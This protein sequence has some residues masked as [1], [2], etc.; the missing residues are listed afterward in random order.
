[1][2]WHVTCGFAQGALSDSCMQVCLTLPVPQDG[3]GCCEDL[4]AFQYNHPDMSVEVCGSS[5]A[6]HCMNGDWPTAYRMCNLAN[7]RLCYLEDLEAT[8]GTGAHWSLC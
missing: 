6:P 2:R 3:S 7:A 5:L 1:M 4:E 8:Q